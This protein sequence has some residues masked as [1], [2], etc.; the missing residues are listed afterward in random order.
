[1]ADPISATLKDLRVAPG[2]AAGLAKRDTSDRLGLGD[3]VA[4][5]ARRA[6]LGEELAQLH[7]RLWAESERSV[8]LVLQGMDTAGKDGAIKKVFRGLNPQGMHIASFKAP[9]D[10]E[11]AHDY[12]WRI[13]AACPERGQIGVFNRSH[14][15]DVVAARIVGAADAKTCKRRFGHLRDFERMLTDEG[16]T[17]AKVFL[18][19]S[20]DEQR[21]R[22][23]A[24][25]DDPTKRWKFK[26]DDLETRAQWSA[27][28]RAYEEA[29]TATSTDDAPWYVVPADRK[30]V[31][32]VAV[33]SLLVSVL[34]TLD[35]QY[36]KA[37]IDLD[38]IVVT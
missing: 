30:W 9:G 37:E 24:R 4:G 7:D 33:A 15:E 13:H 25:L 31:R 14:Y 18:N 6:E 3:K 23:Q 34:R 36:P 21:A 27:Y 12:L 20:C 8:L 32:D 22:L 11:L 10:H 1:M 5:E 16:T 26:Q 17:L 28:Q 38:N 19:I 29:I 2:G 35:P